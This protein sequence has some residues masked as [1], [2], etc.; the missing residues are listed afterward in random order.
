MSG[1]LLLRPHQE[2][3]QRNTQPGAEAA[4]MLP[5][6]CPASVLEGELLGREEGIDK[7]DEIR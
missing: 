7:G 5:K 3:G 6:Y 4:E 2:V 1:C